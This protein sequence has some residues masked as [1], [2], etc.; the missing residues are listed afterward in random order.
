MK[1]FLLEQL[2]DGLND[3]VKAPK[4]STMKHELADQ[5]PQ[6]T[7]ENIEQIRRLIGDDPYTTIKELEE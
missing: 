7:S 5:L 3:F 2:R 6:T 4:K 1:L